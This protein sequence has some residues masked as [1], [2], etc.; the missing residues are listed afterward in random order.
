MCTTCIHTFSEVTKYFV[1]A[2]TCTTLH[3]CTYTVYFFNIIIHTRVRMCLFI[4]YL[5][6]LSPDTFSLLDS[7]RLKKTSLGELGPSFYVLLVHIRYGLNSHNST[8]I[9]TP[10]VVTTCTWHCNCCTHWVHCNCITNNFS[11]AIVG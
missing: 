8:I 9:V 10:I 6:Y 11:S 5:Y 7:R 2:V 4:S 3:V 1:F